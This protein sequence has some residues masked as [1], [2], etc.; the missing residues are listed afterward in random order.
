MAAPL[1][2]QKEQADAIR[3]LSIDAVERA[4]SG[5][6]GMP[7][8]MAD[9]AQ[10]LWA[11]FLR[12]N[13]SNPNWFNRD[14]FILSNGHGSML[15]YALLHLTGYA[16]SIEDLQNF[17][18]LHSITPGHPEHELTPGVETT[19]G[20]LGQGLAHG[21][22][23]AIAESV[24]AGRFNTS[25]GKIVDHRTFVFAGDGCM[26]EG[27]S[28]EACSLAGVLGLGKLIVFYDDNSVSID[29][30]VEPW[31]RDNT[32]QRFLA[33][34]WHVVP[35]VDGHDPKSVRRALVE[36]LQE[37]GKPSILCCKT[38]IGFGSPNKQGSA[39]VHGAPLGKDEV[40]LARHSLGWHYPP[41]E[42]PSHIYKTWDAKEAGR[43]DEAVWNQQLQL[44]LAHNPK[45]AKQ[46]KAHLEDTVSADWQADWK[47]LFAQFCDDSQGIATRKASQK[48]LDK[49]SKMLPQLIGG[50][51]DLA[52]SNG[53][54]ITNRQVV[55][56]SSQNGNFIHYGV[57]E[58]AM[59]AIAVGIA[60]HRGLIPY[61]ATFLVFSDYARN[62][63]RL[64][65]LMC[66]RVIF[67]F[68]HDSIAL[69]EDGPTHQPVEHISSLRLIPNLNVWR[70][71]QGAET[72][73]AWKSAIEAKH[74]PSAIILTRQSVP[75][76]EGKHEH[77]ELMKKM[78]RGGYILWDSTNP[79]QLVI[80]ATG[81]EVCLGQEVCNTLTKA[82]YPVRLVSMPCT[83]IF[84]KQPIEYRRKVL[85]LAVP[86]L[87]IEAGTTA[88]WY[89]YIDGKGT[90]LGIDS[91][92]MSA[93]GKDLMKHYGF[94]LEN[95]YAKALDVIQNNRK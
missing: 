63:I 36:A 61:V 30:R 85:P 73:V 26:M 13:P 86:K 44:F 4:N 7:M 75:P 78:A 27:I 94:T 81:S 6:P 10:I 38:T 32:E 31:F 20:P 43:K 67:I 2:T 62:A 24:L 15:H 21:V 17:R 40:S 42:I 89:R 37:K 12:H 19:T 70:P 28:H 83:D 60:L 47:S 56:A 45:L 1:A 65:A 53:V 91:F 54:M 71:A 58:F 64:A 57:R 41:F 76:L 74:T 35:N 52:E 95:A 79:P 59:C 5:H 18:Q 46:F 66:Q 68:S 77:T 23:M 50:S 48:I 88:W 80:I 34:N 9:I 55:G 29:G 82:G 92:G 33:Y 8:G 3:F 39:Q 90:V 16:V 93:S 84:D 14:R 87:I 69:G 49:C 72:V 51:A 25:K 22:G 11:E